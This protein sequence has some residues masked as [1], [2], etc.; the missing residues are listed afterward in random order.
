MTLVWV[1]AR[2]M[3]WRIILASAS[4][5]VENRCGIVTTPEFLI[6]LTVSPLTNPPARMIPSEGQKNP[7]VQ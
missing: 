5:C 2:S 3:V 1:V 7:S 6:D 4:S